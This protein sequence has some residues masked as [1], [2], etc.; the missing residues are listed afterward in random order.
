MT[1]FRGGCDI[2]SP[3]RRKHRNDGTIVGVISTRS[4]VAFRRRLGQARR[5][6]ASIQ[7]PCFRHQDGLIVG[8]PRYVGNLAV[9]HVCA[10]ARHD[11][12]HLTRLC[13]R[14]HFLV[15]D[16]CLDRLGKED[17]VD[18]KEDAEPGRSKAERDQAGFEML[19]H[20]G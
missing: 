10:C 15:V 18:E 2:D 14:E 4:S 5:D 6:R 9:A 12:V 7:D 13:A 19:L 16:A 3:W 17:G 1:H 8:V 11:V 20:G